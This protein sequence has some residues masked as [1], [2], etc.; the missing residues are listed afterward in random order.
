MRNLNWLIASY[1]RRILNALYHR[2]IQKQKR[3][4][5]LKGSNWDYYVKYIHADSLKEQILIIL[6]K[7][8][9]YKFYDFVR[10]LAILI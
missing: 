5:I 6:L 2:K 4:S 9:L 3:L 7:A 1:Q 8:H 10:F